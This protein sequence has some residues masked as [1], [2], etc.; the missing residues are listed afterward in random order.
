MNEITFKIECLYYQKK[1]QLCLSC[2]HKTLDASPFDSFPSHELKFLL[3]TITNCYYKVGNYEKAYFYSKVLLSTKDKS[4]GTLSLH[5]KI[6]NKNNRP[7]GFFKNLFFLKKK[8]SFNFNFI[9]K[10]ESL[11]FAQKSIDFLSSNIDI[12]LNLVY[13]MDDIK[14]KWNQLKEENK[15]SECELKELETVLEGKEWEEICSGISGK[16]YSVL[17]GSIRSLSQQS[18]A[19]NRYQDSLENLKTSSFSRLSTNL[20]S[21]SSSISNLEF[22]HQL[23]QNESSSI[24][25]YDNPYAYDEAQKLVQI[26]P[27]SSEK[28]IL[29]WYLKN[30]KMFSSFH[31]KLLNMKS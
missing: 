30:S 12:L 20:S 11:L 27:P 1:Y 23:Q 25:L 26:L 3:S 5:S 19:Y 2:I 29:E 31:V 28:T 15:Y 22:K 18:F 8:I 14:F 21:E 16:S 9:L 17:L 24:P 7:L 4:I 10:K 13:I 6:C